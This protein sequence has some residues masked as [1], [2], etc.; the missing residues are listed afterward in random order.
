MIASIVSTAFIVKKYMLSTAN[1]DY[2]RTT[3][4]DAYEFDNLLNHSDDEEDDTEV[5]EFDDTNNRS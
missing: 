3:E 5:F 2:T 4:E 1:L